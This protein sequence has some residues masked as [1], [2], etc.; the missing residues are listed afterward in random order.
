[1][2]S[3][4]AAEELIRQGRVTV[5]GSAAA[6]GDKVNELDEVEVDGKRVKEPRRHVLFMLN[7]PKGVLST[8]S[9]DRGRATV[10]DLVPTIPGLHPVGRL[11]ADSEGLLLVTNDGELTHWLTHPRFEKEKEYRVWSAGGT[12]GAAELG[13]LEKGLE[14]DDGFARAVVAK[15]ADGGCTV[16]VREG[17]NRLIR[18]M[19]A[20]VGHRVVRLKRTRIGGLRLMALEPG[21]YRRLTEDDRRLLEQER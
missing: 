12:L 6:L 10:M 15:V 14:L 19:L 4:R 1:M 20:A 2:A 8:V 16:V 9:D 7:K 13:A 18:R 11:D 5:N 17:R 3:R 21:A